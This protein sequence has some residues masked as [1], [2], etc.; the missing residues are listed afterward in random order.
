MTRPVDTTHEARRVHLGIIRRM[1]GP[2]RVAMAFE[3][4]DAARALTET[5][6]RLRHPDKT[7]AQV[8]DEL[9][10]VLLGGELAE[11]VRDARPIPA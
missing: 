1:S 2:E 7:D 5:G 8:H 6:I 10:T 4:S 3:M 9:L 11:R